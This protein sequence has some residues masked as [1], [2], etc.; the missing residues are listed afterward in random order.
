M[1]AGKMAAQVGHAAVGLYRNCQMSG[2]Q[3]QMSLNQW[4]ENG[5]MKIVL[6]G[7]NASQLDELN[8]KAK[9]AGD[10]FVYLVRD[11]GHTQIPA[12]S[13]TVLGVFGTIEAVDRITGGLKLF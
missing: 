2:E 12:G 5:E 6:K 13:K 9:D 8:R 4:R 11:A 1:G 7:E 10:V 3:G